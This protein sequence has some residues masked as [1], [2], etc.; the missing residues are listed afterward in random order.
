MKSL[1]CWILSCAV[2]LA[3][4]C[5]STSEEHARWQDVELSAPSENVLWA[6]AGQ[7]LQR[8]GFPVGTEANQANN[9]M[10]SGWRTT[11]GAFRGEGHR[12][13]AEIRF[14][15]LDGGRYKLEVRVEREDN[16][17]WVRPSDLGHA[18][19]EAAADDTETAAILVQRIRARLPE[20]LEVGERKKA[21]G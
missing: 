14:E 20:P 9:V 10:R 1:P 11:L 13:R 19:W 8:L 3:G 6:V 17:D 16:M 12:E 2:T 7:E 18:K 4:A 21:R 15:S 5:R